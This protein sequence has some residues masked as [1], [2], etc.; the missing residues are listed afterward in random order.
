MTT[1]CC[2]LRFS[3]CYYITSSIDN[4]FWLQLPI[5]QLICNSSLFIIHTLFFLGETVS[6][7]FLHFVGFLY[8]VDKNDYNLTNGEKLYEIYNSAISTINKW[9]QSNQLK[10]VDIYVHENYTPPVNILNRNLSWLKQFWSSTI[11]ENLGLTNSTN[12]M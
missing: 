7:G 9:N 1:D 2:K 10:F 6:N 3:R 12:I 11:M 8:H 5:S 4:F